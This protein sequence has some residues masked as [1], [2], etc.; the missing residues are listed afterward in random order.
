MTDPSR[1]TPPTC[2]RLSEKGPDPLPSRVPIQPPTWQ[3]VLAFAILYVVW[4]TT[5]LVIQ[6]GV[7]DQQLPPLLFG[8]TRI[9]AAGLILLVYQC[10]RGQSLR[11]S[12][13]DAV[14]IVTGC[15]LLF[16]G[17]NGLITLALQSVQSGESAVLAATATLWIALFSMVFAGGDRLRPIGWLG[18]IVGLVGVMVLQWP[19]LEQQGFSFA[20][21]RGP[22]LTLAS[23]ASWG[24]GTVLLRRTPIC[25]HRLSSAGWQM[26]LGG[27]G[28][29]ILGI[30]N[31]EQAPATITPGVVWVFLYLLVVSSLVAFVAFVWLLEHVSATKVSTYAYVNPLIAVLLGTLLHDEPISTALIAGTLLILVAV[32]LVR[33]GERLLSTNSRAQANQS[34]RARTDSSVHV[35]R[36]R[37]SA[38]AATAECGSS[39]NDPL[40]TSRPE[41]SPTA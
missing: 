3:F 5:Y 12:G 16:L 15:V 35:S 4:G 10:L 7:L 29:C 27:A 11:F 18:L 20:R 13:R 40:A 14:G 1:P 39:A 8:G 36:A 37:L 34:A 32:F 19:N 41:T 17:G 9:G 31:G 22:W 25:I 30:A 23:A 24:I 2:Q 33:G 26:T 28:M 38:V 6:I 21:N